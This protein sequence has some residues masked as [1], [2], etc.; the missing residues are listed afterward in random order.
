MSALC[1]V[2]ALLL[3]LS[4]TASAA[5][6]VLG[7]DLGTEYLKAVLVKPG[8]PL[9]IVL[10]KD[11]K[12]KE[13][14]AL[15]F[16]P[17]R[18]D[19]KG[20]DVFPE[21]VYGSD[22]IALAARFP[23]DVYSNLKPLLGIPVKGPQVQ[24]Y[25]ARHPGHR[26]IADKIRGTVA[27]RSG[28]FGREVEPFSVEEL[29]AMELRNLRG[30]AEAL[31]GGGSSVQDA[32][33]T[34]PA[35]YTAEERRAV[36]LAADLAGLRVLAL[37]SDGLAVGLNYATSRNF[38]SVNDGGN[39]E[40]HLVYDMG[41]GATRATILR[42]QGRTVKDIG[43]FNKTINE[44]TVLGTAYDRQLGGDALNGLI[45]DDMVDRFVET[46]KL[47]ALGT[48]S[49]HI[50]EHGKTMAKLWKEA[51]RLRHVLSA[52]SETSASFEGLFYEDT[53]FKYTLSRAD[54]EKLA[55]SHAE[56]VQVPVSQV[57]GSAKLKMSDLESVILHGGAVRTPFVQKELETAVGDAG[58]IR[59]NVNADESAVF[60]AAFKAAALSPSFKVKDIRAADSAGFAVV[61]S[62]ADNERSQTLFT[63]LSQIGVEKQVP[64]KNLED[65]RFILSQQVPD[66]VS[67]DEIKR[68]VLKVQTNNLTASVSKL[69]EKYGCS[70][71]NITTEFSI[72]LSPVNGLPEVT[73]G[74]VSCE[75][76]GV[77]KKGGVVDGVKGLFGF[78]SKKGDQE[79][80][81][82]ESGLDSTDTSATAP[83]STASSAAESQTTD[84]GPEPD[85]NVAEA[86]KRT[87]TI[88]L[89]FSSERQGI[90]AHSKSELKAVKDRLAAFDASDRSRVLREET[91]N[92]LESYT[93]RVRDLLTD[94]AFLRAS[95]AELRSAIQEKLQSTSDWLY[96]EGAEANRDELKARLK[97][98]RGLVDPV[99]KRNEEALKRPEQI[100]LLKEALDQTGKLI[101][102][103]KEQAEKATSAMSSTTEPSSLT[104]KPTITAS[105]LAAH[106][107]FAELDDEPLSSETTISQTS[108][109]PEMPLYSIQD[110]SA[111]VDKHDSL[112]NWLDAKLAEQEKTAPHQ[113]PVISSTELK[114]KAKELNEA[115]TD[116]LQKK[117]RGPPKPK[118]AKPKAPKKTKKS[119][120]TSSS[121]EAP[122]ESGEVPKAKMGEDGWV[123]TEEDVLEMIKRKA[124]D[125]PDVHDEL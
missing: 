76:E 84:A 35:F 97:E 112:R 123:P 56:R 85:T 124:K 28:S 109:T 99:L 13:T 11:S 53:S 73:G 7:I 64:F 122:T 45:V 16:K 83:A 43:K 74:V 4:S 40:Y 9:E 50:K 104:E 75:T 20:S 102:V 105:P 59:S 113:D 69:M 15:A 115:V 54:F 90:S 106:D 31:A 39:P 10:T 42:F 107:E 71:A 21:R 72:R 80:L 57:L 62:V 82:D 32:V 30:N 67:G 44:V 14:A 61:F 95:T 94:E 49:D 38:P 47:K 19:N 89:S 96:G 65:F 8:I 48:T 36:E 114:A 26:I 33:I 79:P 46:K 93:Y 51:E 5:S 23:G 108:R 3:L 88:H 101:S 24:E 63:P 77:E 41:A 121:E 92:T 37:I 52:N 18:S 100:R 110:L 27:F 29:L 55:S 34:V 25:K 78:G 60:G 1:F 81:K 91:L 17:V 66:L 68:P 119:K 103:V 86:R 70:A 6:A 118:V 12:R 2:L 22:A 111:L 117:M 125:K 87:E 58:K 116:L 98:L 120:T